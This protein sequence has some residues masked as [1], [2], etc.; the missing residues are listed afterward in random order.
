MYKFW[1][2]TNIQF[3]T[4]DDTIVILQVRKLGR[5][6]NQED[7]KPGLSPSLSDS[8]TFQFYQ[9]ALLILLMLSC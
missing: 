8:K 2:G 1:G 7:V 3:I 6:Y 5:L 4:I 9:T